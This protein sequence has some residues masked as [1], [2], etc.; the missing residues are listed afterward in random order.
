MRA[1]EIVL[2]LLLVI[3]FYS[4]FATVVMEFFAG[5]LSMRGKQLLRTLKGILGK[6][7]NG[8]PLFK[9]FEA[10]PLYQHLSGKVTGKSSPP[11]YLA[12]ADF[13]AI[14][15]KVTK[16]PARLKQ[17]AAD[18]EEKGPTL[19]QQ[20]LA[21]FWA[22]SGGNA[23]LFEQRIES[24]YDD[25]MD[26]AVGWYKRK[27]QLLLFLVGVA[28]AVVFN[29]NL[30]EVYHNLST[31]PADEL[32]KLTL[33]AEQIPDQAPTVIQINID[34]ILNTETTELASPTEQGELYQYLKESLTSEKDA[35][36]IGW[37]LDPE[38]KQE[39]EWALRILGWLLMGFCISKGAP[40]W[41]DLLKKVIS[42]RSSGKIPDTEKRSAASA[43]S[44]APQAPPPAT[45]RLN[46]PG[47]QQPVG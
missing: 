4:L 39:K 43:A 40:F 34:S 47:G 46:F 27:V 23:A 37:G 30:I 1:L 26:R 10:H 41:F 15:L 5:I 44:T 14:L 35:L 13:R 2:G 28:I 36:G 17:A 12:A 38:G 45:P 11:S 32:A 22:D 24:W 31:M 25:V 3:L 7:E 42:I 8:V 20:L 29:V 33:I 6:D 19:L 9:A 18:A 21:Q 16:H